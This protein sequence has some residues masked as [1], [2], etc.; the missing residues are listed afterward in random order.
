MHMLAAVI[1]PDGTTRDS[2]EEVVAPIMEPFNEAIDYN[3]GWWDWWQVG[4]RYTGYYAEYD[5]TTDPRNQE[6]CR[7]CAGT[8]TRRDMT[9]ANGCNG[10]EGT[11]TARRWPTDWAPIED[12]IVPA[13]ILLAPGMRLPFS[14][15][16]PDGVWHRQTWN[17]EDWIDDED[18]PATVQKAIKPYADQRFAVVDYHS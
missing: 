18:W 4:G 17:G 15:V 10:C 8:G 11:G 12:D 16:T 7:L 2:A 13:R 3:T 1:V 5:P 9:V 14:V 6:T